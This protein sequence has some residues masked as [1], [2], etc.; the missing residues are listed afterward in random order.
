M[1]T[2]SSLVNASRGQLLCMTYELLL[3]QIQS[4]AHGLVEERKRA[5]EKA[6]KIIGILAGDLDYTYELSHELFRLYVYVQGLLIKGKSK[7]D[8][9]EAYRLIAKLHEAYMQVAKEEKDPTPVM[10]SAQAIYSGLTYGRSCKDEL[11]ITGEERGF[12][13]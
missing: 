2:V 11:Y 10:Q 13:A 5:V 1:V 9:E 7:A 3:E 6:V 8:F 12:K 4:A